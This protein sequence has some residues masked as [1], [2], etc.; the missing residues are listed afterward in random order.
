[1]EVVF[2]EN[3]SQN[4]PSIY[5]LLDPELPK[6]NGVECCIEDNRECDGD[7]AKVTNNGLANLENESGILI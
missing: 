4:G 3:C 2:E 6:Y 1:M 7:V 5:T